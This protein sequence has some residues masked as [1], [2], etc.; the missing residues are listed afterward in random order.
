MVV[1]IKRV[2]ET[3]SKSDGRRILCD[4]FWPRGI[5]KSAARISKWI[6]IIAPSKEL[7]E[8]FHVNSEKRW[9]EFVKKYRKEITVKGSPQ[10]EILKKLAKSSKKSTI[11]IVYSVHDTKYNNAKALRSIIN[12]IAAKM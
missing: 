11:T 6:K 1:G 4:R 10:L 8:W 2:Y 9:K 3:Y 7:I 12:R 5:S